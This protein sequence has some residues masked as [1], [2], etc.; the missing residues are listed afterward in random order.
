VRPVFNA[1]VVETVIYRGF[2]I[3]SNQL[4]ED[5][6]LKIYPLYPFRHVG[7]SSNECFLRIVQNGHC[8]ILL[9][10]YKQSGRFGFKG[11]F[12]PRAR[13]IFVVK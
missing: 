2:H 4:L 10:I 5:I 9:F 3:D 13:K 12:D 1:Y 6:S 7:M 8:G 11:A